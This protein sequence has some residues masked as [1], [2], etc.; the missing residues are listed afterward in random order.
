MKEK[1]MLE[2]LEPDCTIVY[3]KK[4]TDSKL[5]FDLRKTTRQEISASLA[6]GKKCPLCGGDGT[7]SDEDDWEIYSY[8]GIIIHTDDIGYFD[9][10]CSDNDE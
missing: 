2:Q 5:T 9:P 7:I 10:D 3:I 8:R 6:S 4:N 1:L